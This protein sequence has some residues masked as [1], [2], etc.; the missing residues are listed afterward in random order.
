MRK[1]L[2]IALALILLLSMTACGS[3]EGSTPSTPSTPNT[4][5]NSGNAADKITF[6]ELTVVDNEYCT[7]KVT[8][9][10]P[11]SMWGYVLK[12]Y[13]ENKSPDTSFMFSVSSASINGV[14]ADPLFATEIAAGK[15]ANENI[16]FMDRDLEDMIGTFTD[17]E[18][19]FSV[20]DSED[21]SADPVATPSVHVYPYG[22]DKATVYTRESLPSDTIVVD[23]EY[24][25][26]IVT[27]YEVDP[28][29]GYTANL[30]LVNKTDV[31][32]MLS[33]DEVSVNGYMA[34]P[35]YASVLDAGKC[36]FS[37]MSWSDSTFEDNAITEV[38]TI[39]FTLRVHDANDWF[40]DDFVSQAVTLNP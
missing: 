26:V 33:A 27:G 30:Y 25:T 20:S 6:Q 23:N 29:W 37:S 2:A 28:I 18:L 19:S 17:I 34:D 7:I 3:P 39:E 31:S 36:A 35:L 21:W 24:V 38:E 8:G 32:V 15:K 16:T 4:G 14:Q 5:S 9:I 40:A 12:V 10:D 13:L 22:E 11:D 1:I